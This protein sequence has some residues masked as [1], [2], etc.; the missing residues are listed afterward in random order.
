[1][2]R[3]DRL[4]ALIDRFELVVSPTDVEAANLVILRMHD[5]KSSWRL[6][7]NAS[8][9]SEHVPRPSDAVAF[10]AKVTWGGGDNPLFSALPK[11][12]ER[13]VSAPD[14]L[15]L[16]LQL[17]V[18]E[19]EAMRCG[20]ASVLNR[21]GEVLIVRIMREELEKG[22]AEPGVLGG[23][24]DPR[25]S[26]VIVAVHEDP[27][28]A[29]LMEDL[30]NIAGLS[31]SRFADVFL[32]AV[33]ETP[34]AYV[35]RWRLALARQDIERG[36]RIQTVARRYGYAS[37]EALNRAVRRHFGASPTQLRRRQDAAA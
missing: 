15:D 21:L 19:R 4:S 18:A 35:R 16:I 3:L 22:S 5:E 34:L 14:E 17:L 10:S 27:G 31:R 29:W 1:M 9:R 33:G 28:R 8:G 11:T 24:A 13:A 6:F 32:K 36:E 23:L 25:L 30:A 12:I 20:S 2:S 7:L 37:G 26:R